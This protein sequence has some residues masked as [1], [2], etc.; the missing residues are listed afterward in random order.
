MELTKKYKMQILLP[1]ILV[2]VV[3]FGTV[4][5]NMFADHDSSDYQCSLG[6]KYLNDLDY[7]SAI[8]AYSNAVTLD[9]T[10]TEARIGLAKAYNLNGETGFAVE[11]LTDAMNEKRINPEIAEALAEIYTENGDYGRAAG[12]LNDL[13]DQTDSEK[14]YNRV[15]ELFTAIYHR[16]YT[17]STG[18]NHQLK[19]NDTSVMSRGANFFGQLGS[20]NGVGDAEYQIDQYAPSEFPG[21][22]IS[23]FCAGNTSFVIDQSNNLWIAGENRWGQMGKSYGSLSSVGGWSQVTDTGDVV[24]VSGCSGTVFVLKSDGTLFRSGAYASQKLIQC[25]GLPAIIKV[26]VTEGYVY[27]L[28][29]NGILYRSQLNEN[30][31]WQRLTNAS[32]RIS[33]FAAIADCYAWIDDRGAFGNYGVA[34][35][36]DWAYQNDG[37]CMPDVYISEIEV[38]QNNLVFRDANGTVYYLDSNYDCVPTGYTGTVKNVFTDS[39][40]IYAVYEDGTVL[41]WENYASREFQVLTQ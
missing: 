34:M 14:Y 24:Y 36:D 9:P 2:A 18:T 11:I 10:N 30:L 19:L 3:L 13:L 29:V 22:A 16:P 23:V 1:I 17:V 25:G 4:L 20:A 33:D 8:L 38:N 7:S 12:I 35:P 27:A 41:C 39:G 21:E 5:Y 31:S 37:S 26:S 15:I 40:N 32:H 6:K 28:G